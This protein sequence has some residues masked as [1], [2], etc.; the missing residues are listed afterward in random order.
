VQQLTVQ[1]KI[2]LIYFTDQLILVCTASWRW[3]RCWQN[4]WETISFTM[5]VV[6]L[7]QKAIQPSVMIRRINPQY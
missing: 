1:Q 7:Q 6:L 3:V 2:V 4:K 5:L